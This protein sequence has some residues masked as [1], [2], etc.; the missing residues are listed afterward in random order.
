MIASKGGC[1]INEIIS[2]LEAWGYRYVEI[3]VIVRKE[4]FDSCTEGT[5]Y[6]G[7]EPTKSTIR[8]SVS[9]TKAQL[10]QKDSENLFR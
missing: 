4:T 5:A 8:L 3:P 2:W 1:F 10:I 7:L 9:E 6:G